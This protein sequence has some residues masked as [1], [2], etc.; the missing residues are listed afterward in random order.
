MVDA[1]LGDPQKQA[2]G[3]RG[4]MEESNGFITR[5]SGKRHHDAAHLVACCKSITT[6]ST[7]TSSIFHCCRFP[8]SSDIV[9]AT[10][11]VFKSSWSKQQQVYFMSTE[12]V[13]ILPPLVLTPKIVLSTKP[14]YPNFPDCDP[15]C[16]RSSPPI[17]SL[18]AAPDFPF[19]SKLSH[20]DL[21]K[22]LRTC[23]HLDKIPRNSLEIYQD[24]F[25]TPSESSEFPPLQQ[26]QQQQHQQQT[27]GL[28]V[29]IIQDE[30]FPDLGESFNDAT[31][32]TEDVKQAE[33]LIIEN[34]DQ[35]ITLANSYNTELRSEELV[36]VKSVVHGSGSESKSQNGLADV[37][38]T[39][40]L[41]DMSTPNWIGE[42]FMQQH[43][44]YAGKRENVV[45]N[46]ARG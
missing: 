20:C 43:T 17:E 42:P 36:V 24:N 40:P 4:I 31:K 25:V 41:A 29:A 1:A 7:T 19:L 45:K 9:A 38:A 13:P 34:I 37:L 33:G 6:A 27:D 3:D 16:D 35:E 2:R 14:D 15:P 11:T 39:H 5:D 44:Y 23:F 30:K 26:Q 28:D 10:T 18:Y 46:I 8:S 21:E 32:R 22:P 12:P